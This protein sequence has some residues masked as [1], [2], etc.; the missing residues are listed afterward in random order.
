MAGIWKECVCTGEGGGTTPGRSWRRQAGLATFPPGLKW[1]RKWGSRSST[2]R[3][4]RSSRLGPRES[5]YIYI[6]IIFGPPWPRLGVGQSAHLGLGKW[7]P[8]CCASVL[9]VPGSDHGGGER[10][11]RC[12]MQ[13]L[14]PSGSRTPELPS[15][16]RNTGSLTKK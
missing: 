5:A 14:I 8:L 2:S 6:Y 11:P 3:T 16:H 1:L 4:Q 12:S 15:G 7:C 10:D 13:C 9:V